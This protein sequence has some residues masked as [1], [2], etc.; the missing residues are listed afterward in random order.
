[1]LTKKAMIAVTAGMLITGAAMADEEDRSDSAQVTMSVTNETL[2]LEG[3]DDLTFPAINLSSNSQETPE[4]SFC[5][6]QSGVDVVNVTLTLTGA[7]DAN[8]AFEMAHESVE[9][10]TI[11]YLLELRYTNRGGDGIDLNK[12]GPDDIS[13]PDLMPVGYDGECSGFNFTVTASAATA[14]VSTALAGSYSDTL[15][16][17]VAAN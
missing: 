10:E 14:D 5:V 2:L 11:P 4:D 8:G 15:T 13:V 7:N 6:Y 9:D 16:M 17:T 12:T 1:M 3:L